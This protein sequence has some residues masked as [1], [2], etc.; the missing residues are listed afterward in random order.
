MKREVNGRAGFVHS[1]LSARFVEPH[2]MRARGLEVA[3]VSK[4]KKVISNKNAPLERACTTS[5]PCPRCSSSPSCGRCCKVANGIV[6]YTQYAVG[7]HYRYKFET[8]H[9]LDALNL[10]SMPKTYTG[11][12]TLTS[13]THGYPSRMNSQKRLQTALLLKL[14]ELNT[15]TMYENIP[16]RVLGSLFCVSA[17]N[18]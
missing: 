5:N 13:Y 11:N 7:I 16:M 1:S 4:I 15:K 18:S 10:C 2:T 8:N 9:A 12:K 14:I 17:K 3:V 6:L